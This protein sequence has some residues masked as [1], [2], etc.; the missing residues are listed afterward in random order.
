[1]L[2]AQTLPSYG[3]VT[4]ASLAL[5]RHLAACTDDLRIL[6]LTRSL[7]TSMPACLASLWLALSEL[8]WP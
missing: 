6:S 2:E 8:C 3:Q 4:Q 1:M 5:S 7:L